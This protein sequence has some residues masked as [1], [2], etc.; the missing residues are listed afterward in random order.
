MAIDEDRVDG[1]ELK[2][3][4]ELGSDDRLLRGLLRAI[5]GRVRDGDDAPPG[6]AD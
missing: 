2:P 4:D 3:P 5:I 6:S 1:R